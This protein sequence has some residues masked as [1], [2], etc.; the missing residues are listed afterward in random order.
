MSLAKKLEKFRSDEPDTDELLTVLDRIDPEEAF[1]VIL[2]S[3]DFIA[4]YCIF[5]LIYIY[6]GNNL[7]AP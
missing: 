6:L 5:L 1:I 2:C 3:I 4:T 7:W